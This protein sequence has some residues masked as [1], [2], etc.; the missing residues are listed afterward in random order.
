MTSKEK[1]QA[2]HELSMNAKWF[3]SENDILSKIDFI[4]KY[5]FTSCE[6]CIYK[7]DGVYMDVCGTCK[8]YYP[9]N[10]ERKDNQ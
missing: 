1:S 2:I 4:K 7:I 5:K 3:S 10:F 8:H 9:C 6:D